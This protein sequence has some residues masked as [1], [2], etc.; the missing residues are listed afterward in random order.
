MEHWLPY[1]HDRLETLFDYLPGAA[2]TLDDQTEEARAARW[3]GIAEQQAARA[4]ALAT[5]GRGEPLPAL[6]PGLCT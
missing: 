5:A 2:V 1:F 4:A 6:P 3:E